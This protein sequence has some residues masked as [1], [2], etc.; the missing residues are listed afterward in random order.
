VRPLSMYFS[1]KWSPS[2]RAFSTFLTKACV[3]ASAA[4]C[5]G[6]CWRIHGYA[7][8]EVVRRS[9]PGLEQDQRRD[10]VQEQQRAS[11][12]RTLTPRSFIEWRFSFRKFAVERTK[13]KLLGI[14]D[15]YL[16]TVER[17]TL[18]RGQM[19]GTPMSRNRSELST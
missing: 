11:A 4:C 3:R 9:A 13:L 2:T 16:V 6:S 19:L 1:M 18:R 17:L 5:C 8:L 14:V 12:A 10:D 7:A 15:V